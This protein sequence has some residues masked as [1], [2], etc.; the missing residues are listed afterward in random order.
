VTIIRLKSNRAADIAPMVDVARPFAS[1]LDP[2][3][4]RERGPWFFAIFDKAPL[5]MA[6]T[7]VPDGVR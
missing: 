6:L 1:S 7:R 4:M 5:A 2:N 3:R